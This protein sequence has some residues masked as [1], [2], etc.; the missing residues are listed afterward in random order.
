MITSYYSYYGILLKIIIKN[1]KTFKFVNLL[2]LWYK[3][4]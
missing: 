3:L 1:L 2:I 4:Y